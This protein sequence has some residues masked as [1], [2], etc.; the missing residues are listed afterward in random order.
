MLDI[1]KE[2][3]CKEWKSKNWQFLN[4]NTGKIEFLFINGILKQI[5]ELS[6][7]EELE[8]LIKYNFDVNLYKYIE[9]KSVNIYLKLLTK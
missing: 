7:L 2:K 5:K 3:N 8:N 6:I 4:P 1:K 9:N